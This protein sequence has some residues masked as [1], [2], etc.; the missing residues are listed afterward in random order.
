MCAVDF[1]G[2]SSKTPCLSKQMDTLKS[3]LDSVFLIIAL[4]FPGII[5]LIINK[6]GKI[7][8]RLLI[9]GFCLLFALSFRPFSNFLLWGLES[10]HPPLMDLS[11]YTNVKYIVVLT[12]WDCNIPSIPYTSN[13][14]YQSAFR[15]LEAHR[16]YKKLP[17]AEIIISGSKNGGK[18]MKRLLT[19]LGV[20]AQD[21]Q[22][23]YAG[24]TWQ[25]GID[26][27]KILG[28]RK[29]FLVTSAIH[30]PRSIRSFTSEGLKP[31]PAP[32]DYSYGYY[33]KY[34]VPFPRPFSY[35]IPNTDSL[36][37]SNAALYEYMGNLWYFIKEMGHTS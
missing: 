28:D 2:R 16:I 26:V 23:D 22:I 35:Y 30:L 27:K 1:Y 18:L 5:L 20:P 25:S 6:K 32:A 12:A 7:A 31:I 33:P 36:I 10:R 34:H 3:C 37:R 4:I 9:I 13:L 14:G 15:T 17:H 24:N 19:L 8:R 11:R 21:I 29:F